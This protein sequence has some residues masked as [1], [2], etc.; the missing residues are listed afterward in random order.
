M[1]R[2]SVVQIRRTQVADLHG[3]E[4]QR[5]DAGDHEKTTTSPISS[6]SSGA[7]NM[8][9]VRMKSS[10]RMAREEMTTVRV[11]ART[12]LGGGLAS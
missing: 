5:T 4:E 8:N 9:A 12:P 3:E 11:V 1:Q 6:C 10:P 2:I 7:P